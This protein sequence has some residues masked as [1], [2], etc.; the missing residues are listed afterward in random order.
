MQP[1]RVYYRQLDVSLAL[2]GAH[3]GCSAMARNISGYFSSFGSP[4]FAPGEGLLAEGLP[5]ADERA[6]SGAALW[7]RTAAKSA[8][9]PSS[10]ALIVCALGSNRMFAI[11]L[12][13]IIR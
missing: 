2:R 9:V 1:Y 6:R 7:A 8:F 3:S 12:P 11:L 13:S 5:E 10:V 4:G